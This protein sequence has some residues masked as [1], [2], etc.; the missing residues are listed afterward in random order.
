MKGTNEGTGVSTRCSSSIMAWVSEKHT[1]V[2]STHY[3]IV[4][5]NG[6]VVHDYQLIVVISIYLGVIFSIEEKQP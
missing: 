1:V 6:I 3:D 4:P 2:H 5:I